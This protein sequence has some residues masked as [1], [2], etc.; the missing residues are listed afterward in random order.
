MRTR[1]PAAGAERLEQ[2]SP[3]Q[4]AALAIKE[5]RARLDQQEGAV[6]EPIGHRGS[7][8]SL[9]AVRWAGS[10]LASAERRA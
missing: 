3:L 1:T 2:L 8:L 7:G 10:L 6:R 9:S 4:K 5:L